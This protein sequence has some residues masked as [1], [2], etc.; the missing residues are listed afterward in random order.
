MNNSAI[1]SFY[2]FVSGVYLDLNNPTEYP[3]SRVSSWFLDDSNI[4]NLNNLIGTDIQRCSTPPGPRLFP[5][6]I[7][8]TFP[9]SSPLIY[10]QTS[11]LN[12]RPVYIY[13]NPDP[14]IVSNVIKYVVNQDYSVY[15]KANFTGWVSQDDSIG[16][17]G[18]DF[19]V[20]GLIESDAF[21]VTEIT[22][23]WWL[24]TVPPSIGLYPIVA[25]GSEKISE[26]GSTVEIPVY[27]YLEPE[28]NN[29]QMAIY[30]KLFECNFYK[31]QSFDIAKSVSMVGDWVSIKDGDSSIT[32]I[33]KNEISKNLRALYKDSYEELQF[34][35]KM[36]LKKTSSAEQI[37]GDD[38][39]GV[40]YY[41]SNEKPRNIT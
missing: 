8:E 26:D 3:I 9:A 40:N 37:S 16:V 25:S 14:S 1:D 31:K 18:V 6:Y 4:G 15:G 29:D 20:W 10:T 28:L 38:F 7:E 33:N 13:T 36:Y 39:I 23:N 30:K 11:F 32:R 22:G 34:L 17:P 24:N 41:Y 12:N 2:N 27:Y 21:D 5:K 19:I 35:I